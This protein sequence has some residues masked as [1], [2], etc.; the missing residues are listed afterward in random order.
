MSNLA[1]QDSPI[2]A[3]AEIDVGEITDLQTEVIVLAESV[4]SSVRTASVS[5]NT[6][7]APVDNVNQNGKNDSTVPA[8]SV[9]KVVQMLWITL[10]SW[11]RRTPWCRRC[12]TATCHSVTGICCQR[13]PVQND[14]D[15]ENEL[16]NDL[17]VRFMGLT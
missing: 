5:I 4:E 17:T 9:T 8:S 2:Q 11:R 6:D 14:T 10:R 13:K 1:G 12:Q 3:Q 16:I 15:S 7:A